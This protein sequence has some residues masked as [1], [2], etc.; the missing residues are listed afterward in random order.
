MSIGDLHKSFPVDYVGSG[1]N[2]TCASGVGK[3]TVVTRKSKVLK[4]CT[5]IFPWKMME[6]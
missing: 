1:S 2:D 4:S 3:S 6:N 5:D